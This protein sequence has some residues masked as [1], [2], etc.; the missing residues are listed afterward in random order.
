MKKLPFKTWEY[1]EQTKIKHLVFADYF[2]RWVKILGKY[3]PLNYID[4]FG[5]I[6]AYTENGKY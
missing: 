4:G 3:N 6:G 1:K 2:D 5:G